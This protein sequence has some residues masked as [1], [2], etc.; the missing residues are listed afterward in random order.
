MKKIILLSLIILSFK[1]NAQIS[2]QEQPMWCWAS[3]IQSALWQANVVQSQSQIVSRLAGYPQNRPANANEIT[4]LLQ[5]YNFKSW[6]VPY[7]ANYQQL[8]ITLQ[9]GWKLIAFVNPTNNPQVGHFI[10]LQRISNNGLI[11]VSDPASGM[12]YE[13]N[14]EQL[15]FAWKWGSSVVVGTP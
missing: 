12:T 1:V 10:I 2:V 7:P 13:Q 11:V 14:A 15:Y 6:T 9:T 3:C 8:Y 4:Y 5:T